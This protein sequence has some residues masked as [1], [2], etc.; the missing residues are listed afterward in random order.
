MG[1]NNNLI[2][3]TGTQVTKEWASKT[4]IFHKILLGSK[5]P[6]YNANHLK[7]TWAVA[8]TTQEITANNQALVVDYNNSKIS[9]V[10]TKAK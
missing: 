3:K 10:A 7:T 5:G 8:Y 2:R 6:K 9:V 4:I 1:V